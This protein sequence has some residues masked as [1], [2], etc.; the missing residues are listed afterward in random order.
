[1]AREYVD[2]ATAIARGA[3]RAGCD[4]FGGYPISPATPILLHM[5][6]ELP[7]VGGV[8]I[9]AED[10]IGAISMCIGAAIAGARPFTAT[11]GPGISLYSENIGLAIMGEVPLVIVNVMRMG[12]ATG[13]ATTPAVFTAAGQTVAVSAGVAGRT[14]SAL[15]CAMVE[16]GP[17][18]ILVRSLRNYRQGGQ[19][20][21]ADHQRD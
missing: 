8:G 11:A 3:L 21:G 2:G 18:P 9:Q 14:A 12:P 17:L 4:F 19:L 5:L 7:K 16:H 13:G 10:E 6:R 1:M 15:L 20:K